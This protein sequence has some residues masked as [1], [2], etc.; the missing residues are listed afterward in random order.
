MASV[1]EHG[2]TVL[3]KIVIPVITTVLGATAIYFLGFNKKSSGRTD[4]EQLLISK[5]ATVKAWKSYVVSQNIAYE[6][7]TSIGQEFIENS[8]KAAKEGAGV[9]KFV[10]IWT[11]YRDNLLRETHKALVDVE[12]MLKDP[13]LDRDFISFLNRSYEAGKVDEKTSGAFFDRILTLLQGD[14]DGTEKAQKM[15][16][17]TQDFVNA[18]VRV[19]DRSVREA[20]GIARILQERYS[21]AFD[22]NQLKIWVDYKAG[23]FGKPKTDSTG[24]NPNPGGGGGTQAPADPNVRDD[25]RP[26]ANPPGE[27]PEIRPTI[28]P[29]NEN[30]NSAGNS[31]TPT[32]TL[33]TGVWS[34]TDGSGSLE[35]S[36]NGKMFWVFDTRGYTS[37]DWA[38]GNGQLEMNAANPDTKQRFYIVGDISDFNQT[39]FTLSF[40][41]GAMKGVYH[42][43]KGR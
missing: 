37:G 5:E 20:E 39:S 43:R 27:Q 16:T 40:A 12:N 38:L 32:E 9:E 13:D 34:M 8:N 15:Q 36:A 6:N 14:M 26:P 31:V 33:L 21:Q 19:A 4:M 11:A 10:E 41:S 42:F 24:L 18:T 3:N 30:R 22:L 2:S 25:N 17:E 29:A 28:R 35:L 1:S 7:V 23:K